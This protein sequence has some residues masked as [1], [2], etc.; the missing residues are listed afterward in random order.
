MP[1]TISQGFQKLRENLEISNLQAST[2]STRQKNVREAVE[3][4]LK[5]L[6]SFLTGSYMRNTMIAPLKGADIDIFV[7][8]DPSY[9]DANGQASLL[10]RVQRVLK[11][12]YPQSPRVSRNGQAVTITFTDFKVDVVP[13]FYRQGGGY[14]IPDPP[15]GRWIQTDP[16]RH[17]EIW[18]DANKRRDGN[19]VPLIKMVK[20]WNKRHS[21]LLRSFHLESLVLTVLNNVKVSD[22]PSGI[23]YIFDKARTA[24]RTPITDPAGYGSNIGGYLT[25]LA[26]AD[27]ASR[28]E[29]AYNRAREAELLDSQGRIAAAFVKW[30][31]IFDEYFPAYG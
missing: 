26:L 4:E 31:L 9:Y 30:R 8:L 10:D 19:L 29:T 27:V 18:T 25:T 17:V 14:L 24:V 22:F 5:V 15:R 7:V 6:D 11:K 28:L 13:G 16:K 23:R 2:T 20:G 12:T 1:R 21:A 3:A